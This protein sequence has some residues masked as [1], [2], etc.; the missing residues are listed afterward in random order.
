MEFNPERDALIFEE[1]EQ[2]HLECRPIE[3]ADMFVTLYFAAVNKYAENKSTASMLA[4]SPK[5]ISR[6]YANMLTSQ[7]EEIFGIMTEMAKIGAGLEPEFFG[8]Y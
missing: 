7:N 2:R 5:K 1:V 6:D 8:I 4:G 3:P